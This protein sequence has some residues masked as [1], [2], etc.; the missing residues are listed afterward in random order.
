M[1]F[2]TIPF[3]AGEHRCIKCSIV[4]DKLESTTHPKVASDRDLTHFYF[5]ATLPLVTACP[6]GSKRCLGRAAVE[7]RVHIHDL[8]AT[9]PHLL[10]LDHARLTFQHAS[11]N[12]RLTDVVGSVGPEIIA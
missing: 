5:P 12:Y 8:H 1:V 9:V 4:R 6:R 7:N 3:F 10:G 11:R 2:G